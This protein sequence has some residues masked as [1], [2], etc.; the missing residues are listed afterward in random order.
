MMMSGFFLVSQ[1]FCVRVSGSVESPC[2][3]GLLLAKSAVY[4]R[5]LGKDQFEPRVPGGP[6]GWH[7]ELYV[8][9]VDR[10]YVACPV[11]QRR[12]DLNFVFD[13]MYPLGERGRFRVS[14]NDS[15]IQPYDAQS[16]QLVA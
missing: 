11:T 7:V 16:P 10:T 6:A 3:S 2:S 12:S 8:R 9:V 4:G 15:E 1:G 14:A 13:R 5:D